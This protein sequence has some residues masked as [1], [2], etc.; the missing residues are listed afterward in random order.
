MGITLK[1]PTSL[2]E[3]LEEDYGPE[4]PAQIRYLKDRSEAFLLDIL[5]SEIPPQMSFITGAV[6]IAAILLML[7]KDHVSVGRIVALMADKVEEIM[8]A[9]EDAT[10]RSRQDWKD[11]I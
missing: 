2:E 1:I 3:E 8:Q 4:A 7:K 5:K 11:L 10:Y 6:C 9:G